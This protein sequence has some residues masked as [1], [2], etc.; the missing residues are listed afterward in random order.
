MPQ[1]P[2]KDWPSTLEFKVICEGVHHNMKLTDVY[3]PP[4]MNTIEYVFSKRKDVFDECVVYLN[5]EEIHP[6]KYKETW[7]SSGDV[8]EL[9]PKI[10]K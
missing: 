4:E 9:V 10:Y 5:G 7:V 6:E 3:Y 1:K 8:I 2:S